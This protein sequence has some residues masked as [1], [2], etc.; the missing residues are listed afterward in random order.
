MSYTNS[1]TPKLGELTQSTSHASLLYPNTEDQNSN[2]QV[3]I[4]SKQKGYTPNARNYKEEKTKTFPE[5]SKSKERLEKHY[6]VGK[7]WK[8]EDRKIR[9]SPKKKKNPKHSKKRK[10]TKPDR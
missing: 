3:T 4:S 7:P 9:E 10:L 6:T 5:K 8:Q 2:A 1:T